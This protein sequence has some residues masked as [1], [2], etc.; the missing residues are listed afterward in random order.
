MV[1]SLFSYLCVIWL[2]DWFWLSFNF[3]EDLF[4]G[5]PIVLIF[6]DLLFTD[7]FWDVRDITP[8][9]LA[10]FWQSSVED[11][12]SA[13]LDLNVVDDDLSS[14]INFLLLF[15][16][17][18]CCFATGMPLLF[19]LIFEFKLFDISKKKEKQLESNLDLDL[20]K[21]IKYFNLFFKTNNS[22]LFR[23]RFRSIL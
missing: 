12:T 10:M 8:S 18:W 23:P 1:I 6:N 22:K 13:L 20:I 17:T 5:K 21:I 11:W 15:S 14:L 9:V 16:S 4:V 2:C 19:F 7:D 3:L